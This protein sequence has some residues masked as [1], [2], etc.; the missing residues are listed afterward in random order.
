M[1][2]C[3]EEKTWNIR[4]M[5]FSSQELVV[6]LAKTWTLRLPYV[7][8][9]MVVLVLDPHDE[10]KSKLLPPCHRSLGNR[11]SNVKNGNTLERAA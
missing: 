2:E 8:R 4:Q 11:C 9:L 5:Q 6:D 1:G 7:E 10:R 3:Q